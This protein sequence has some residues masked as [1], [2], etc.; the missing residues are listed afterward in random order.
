M[1]STLIIGWIV[2]LLLARPLASW[3]GRGR[4]A[5]ARGPRRRLYLS[6]ALGIASIG[7]ITLGI[8]LFTGSFA[9]K[10]VLGSLAPRRLMLLSMLMLG[11]CLVLW[12]VIQLSRKMR[13]REPGPAYVASLPRTGF[14]KTVF[15]ANSLWAGVVEEYAYRG[16]C[17]IQLKA[18]TGSWGV[19][20]ALTSV[21][22]GFGR[23]Y[24]DDGISVRSSLIGAVLAVPVI[25]T[26]SV[27]P[28]MVGHAAIDVLSGLWGYRLFAR[29]GLLPVAVPAED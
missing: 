6:S 14:E 1:K 3:R 18:L 29:W 28:A 17:L 23:A 16:F 27:L 9:L 5:I 25:L 4:A 11:V 13:R 19:A 12:L 24:V 2:V 8:D 15:T 22:F 21:G 10:A 7:M 20:L 26:G